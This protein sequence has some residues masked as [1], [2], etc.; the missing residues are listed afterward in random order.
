MSQSH[1]AQF[2]EAI[3]YSFTWENGLANYREAET[4][5]KSWLTLTAKDEIVWANLHHCL[6]LI[7]SGRLRQAQQIWVKGGAVNR[8]SA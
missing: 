4:I 6:V 1:I 3:Q 5:I 8:R 7:L 2:Y